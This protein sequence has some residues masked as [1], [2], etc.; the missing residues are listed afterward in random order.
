MIKLN[1]GIE[2][3]QIGLGT[4]QLSPKDCE[5]AVFHALKTGYRLIDTA[6][7]YKNEEAVATA[8]KKSK[9]PREEIFLTTKLWNSDHKDALKAF[10]TS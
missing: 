6:A 7:I 5:Q 4:W 1:N 10:N 3:P 9:I 2:I 8:I